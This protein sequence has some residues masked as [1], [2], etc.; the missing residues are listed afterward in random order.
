MTKEELISK[1]LAP[2]NDIEKSLGLG[3]E[4]I[5]VQLINVVSNILNSQNDSTDASVEENQRVSSQRLWCR[6][7]TLFKVILSH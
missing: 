1:T 5:A 3:S 6:Q 4:K 7:V 2:G